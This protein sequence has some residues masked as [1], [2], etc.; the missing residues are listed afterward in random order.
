MKL[1][2]TIEE[3]ERSGNVRNGTRENEM[4][5]ETARAVETHIKALIN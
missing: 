1:R 5:V 2:R 3:R 4:K